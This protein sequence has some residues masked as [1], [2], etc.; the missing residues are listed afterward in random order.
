MP[1]RFSLPTLC[2]GLDLELLWRLQWRE[3]LTLHAALDQRPRD[4]RFHLHAT[5]WAGCLVGYRDAS[6]HFYREMGEV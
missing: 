2:S 3:Y 6:Q 5:S 1:R 4:E